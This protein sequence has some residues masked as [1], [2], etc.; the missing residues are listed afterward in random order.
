MYE[1]EEESEPE[2]EEDTRQKSA[3]S[4]QNDSHRKPL[5]FCEN[6]QITRARAEQRRQNILEKRYGGRSTFRN[7]NFG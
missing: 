6:P 5:D 3:S 2:P 7:S 4:S 1:V